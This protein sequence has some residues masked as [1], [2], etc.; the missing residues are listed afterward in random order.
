MY[1]QNLV[2][3]FSRVFAP[4]Q[5]SLQLAI[6]PTT[7]DQTSR[8][9][10]ER[11]SGFLTWIIWDKDNKHLAEFQQID[12]INKQYYKYFLLNRIYLMY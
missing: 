11:T 8:S 3:W 7:T 10:V 9:I 5:R 12:D 6:C 2:Y 1:T 4:L